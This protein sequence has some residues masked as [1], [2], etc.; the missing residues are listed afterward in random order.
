[1]S[2]LMD[3]HSKEINAKFEKTMLSI[4]KRI[5]S[6]TASSNDGDIELFGDRSDLEGVE[7][8]SPMSPEKA[9]KPGKGKGRVEM[10]VSP[11]AKPAKIFGD[12]GVSLYVK[13]VVALGLSVAMKSI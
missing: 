10:D 6:I 2:P 5:G 1:M 9:T 3:K 4:R 7:D 12:T 11:Y 8:R 13:G